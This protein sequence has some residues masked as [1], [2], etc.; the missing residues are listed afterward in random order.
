MA[1]M[2]ANGDGGEFL[3]AVSEPRNQISSSSSSI[4]VHIDL[5]GYSYLTW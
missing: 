2:K 3:L 4:R 1:C 5:E